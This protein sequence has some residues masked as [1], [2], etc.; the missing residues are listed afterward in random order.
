M[1]YFITFLFLAIYNTGSF[2]YVSEGHEYSLTCNKDGYVLT[3]RLPVSRFLEAGVASRVVK[4]N[5]RIYLG[6]NCDASHSV[7]G[8]GKWCWANGG[9]GADFSKGEVWFPRQELICSQGKFDH[10]ECGCK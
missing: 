3:S 6:K 9:F 4:S 1:R 2:A 7:M 8:G 5:E 10:E